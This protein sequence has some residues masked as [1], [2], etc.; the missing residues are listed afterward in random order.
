[1]SG[2]LGRRHDA[3][4]DGATCEAA[5]RERP[6]PDG[7][8][9]LVALDVDGTLV[10]YDYVMSDEVAQA[11]ADLDAAGHHVVIATGRSVHATEEVVRKTGLDEV[12][13]VVS[14]GAVTV[15]FCAAG[16]P[17][18]W[19]VI[20]HVT[21]DATR[22][23]QMLAT[24]LPEAVFAVE[25]VGVGYRLT[26]PFPDGELTGAFTVT[27][28]DDLSSRPV[29]RLVVRSPDHTPEAFHE[30]AARMGFHDVTYAIGYSAWMDIAPAGVTKASALESIR[31]ELGVAPEL[32]V[33]VGDGRNDVDMLGWAA[34]GV[35]M[36]QA[37]DVVRA[38]A[39]E[40][41]GTIAQDGVLPV[42]RSVLAG[43]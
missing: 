21:F 40:V 15:R 25:D 28:L 37:D 26:A 16:G 39:N 34:R 1:M 22:V 31:R 18:G 32:T 38:A 3:V 19:R 6:A 14:N 43:S 42:L 30:L 8:A 11:V 2:P 9:R 17:P 41:T 23:I 10:T 24:E 12:W 29:T 36:G 33:A 20:D 4:G 13:G 7:G 5:V 27:D 35:A